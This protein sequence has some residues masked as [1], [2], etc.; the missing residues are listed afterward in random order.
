MPIV[1]LNLLDF[2]AL[3]IGA[4]AIDSPALGFLRK[5]KPSRMPALGVTCVPW[6]REELAAAGADR[7]VLLPDQ[8]ADLPGEIQ[9]L[10][11]RT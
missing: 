3:I 1:V 6:M 9:D 11:Q 4:N 7:V 2:D 5:W 8:I 10:L